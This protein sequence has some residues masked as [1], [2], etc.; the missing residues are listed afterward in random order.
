MQCSL[1]LDKL[2]KRLEYLTSRCNVG[3]SKSTPDELSDLQGGE[4]PEPSD[5]DQR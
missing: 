2:K 5:L 1:A 3:A 4:P